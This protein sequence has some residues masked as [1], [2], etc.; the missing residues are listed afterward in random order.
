M[1]GRIFWD[2]NLFIYLIE[3]SD[4]RGEKVYALRRRMIERGDQLLTSAMTVA[5]V[6]VQPLRVGDTEL[7]R[8]YSD[9]LS[10]RAADVIT[11]D[12]EA[13]GVYAII[14]ARTNVRP[15]DAIQLSCA[16][17]G[18]ADMFVT[19]DSRL[20]KLHVPEIPFIVSLDRVPF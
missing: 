20:Q 18:N 17:K 13:A 14:R 16:V 11:F 3:D 5:E 1:A 12:A 15:P 4:D 2:T 19:N 7:A 9:L 6:L 8:T 10:D